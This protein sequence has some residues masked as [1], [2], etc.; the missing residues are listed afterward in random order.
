MKNIVTEK[1]C[2]LCKQEK[3]ILFFYKNKTKSDGFSNI[4]KE[5]NKTNYKNW[6]ADNKERKIEL[7]SNWRKHTNNRNQEKRNIYFREYYKN[8]P[9][10]KE[11]KRIYT[12]NR[13]SK[14]KKIGG[15]ISNNE[16]SALLQKYENRCL[17]CKRSDVKLTIDHVVP[18]SKGG[19]NT[20]DNVQPLCQSCNSRKNAKYIDFR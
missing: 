7:E 18:I 15:K 6:C 12:N 17:C 5:C 2:C 20:I 19:T 16:W 14:I 4:C 10:R 1:R 11:T 8:H 9:E 13:N 3:N